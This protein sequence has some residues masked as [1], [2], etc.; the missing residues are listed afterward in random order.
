VPA[1]VAGGAAEFQL[2]SD[3][4]VARLEVG[5]MVVLEQLGSA[6]VDADPI[7]FFDDSFP[8]GGGVSASRGG[9]DRASAP[10]ASVV[11]DARSAQAR[12]RHQGIIESML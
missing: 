6:A 2:V 3:G 9:V 8:A 10:R 11:V 12:R 5:D 1:A 4:V 7:A